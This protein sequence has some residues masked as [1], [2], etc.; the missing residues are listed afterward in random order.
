[1]PHL[2]LSDLRAIRAAAGRR[3][4]FV[5]GQFNVVHPGHIRLLKFARSLADDL[6]AALL[7]DGDGAYVP[8]DLRLAAVRSLDMVS[9][10]FIVKDDLQ[11]CL[12]ALRPD[13]VVKGAEYETRDNPEREWLRPWNGRLVF[14]T[15]DPRFSLGD[16]IRGMLRQHNGAGLGAVPSGYLARH[17]ITLA[18]FPSLLERMS[19]LRVAVI[20]DLIVDEYV[21]CDPLGMSREDPTLVVSPVEETCFVGG[22]GIVA[23]HAAGLGG[24]VDFITV[25][26]DD[27]AAEFAGGWLERQGVA[28]HI[29]IDPDRPTTIKR[30]YRAQNKT[31]L[32]VN[33]MSRQ[34]IGGDRQEAI[35]EMLAAILPETDLLIFSD[36]SYGVLPPAL[37]GRI[38]AQCLDLGV[39]LAADS[40]SSSQMGDLSKFHDAVLTTP[41]ELEARH[42]LRDFTLGLTALAQE[43]MAKT[44]TRNVVVTLGE[45]G[46]LIHGD[47]NA[48]R[49]FT[50]NLPSLNPRPV[51]VAGAGDSLL[52]AAAMALAAGAD[53]WLAAL[54]GNVAAGIQVGRMGN[55]PLARDELLRALAAMDEGSGS[56]PS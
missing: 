27:R 37:V 23:G 16:V 24:K 46:C 39:P 49:I 3:I 20:G 51:D 28:T 30:R 45:N 13:V 19:R 35:M 36:F 10:A 41:T 2:S 56:N 6:V 15:N 1:M 9:H 47:P 52:A 25:A 7:P 32:R 18:S 22:A 8:Q 42:A 33:R 48:H 34:H 40:Q 31:L 54:L 53:I 55:I 11:A 44:S 43:L 17:G 5:S 38:T 4:A 14:C 26:G 50:D 21:L 29:V 12:D